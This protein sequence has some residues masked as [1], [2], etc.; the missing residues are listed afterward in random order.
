MRNFSIA[1]L[2]IGAALVLLA[3]LPAGTDS[4][5][6]G[7]VGI[8]PE[9]PQRIVSL[10]PG[11]TEIL[12]ALGAGDR[13]V[14]VTSY[15]DY[16][17]EAK[18]KPTVGGYHAP[19][20]EKVIALE[21]DMVFAMGE[22]QDKYVRMLR[23]AGIPVVAKEPKTM[24]E[25]LEAIDTISS[26]IGEEEAGQALRYDLERRLEGVRQRTGSAPPKQV[27][28]EVWSAPFLTVGSQSFINDLI[29][30]AGG[31][32]VVAHRKV[33]YTTC[34]IEALYSY[35][36]DVYVVIRHSTSDMVPMITRADLAD[37]GAVKNNQVFSV[38]DD[39]LVRPGPR[40]FIGLVKMAEIL[41]PEAMKQ[42][43]DK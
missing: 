11:N 19:D 22:I 42:A 6:G 30:Q 18:T 7:Q 21:P 39:L 13:V 24:G 5:S 43:G 1:L 35:N 29:T 38:D 41:H 25:I 34:D 31:T 16:P 10:S 12:F 2:I 27:F 36:P 23:K 4:E 9:K 26:A 40:S 33:D 20:L 32:N 8:S 3:A 14:G 28:L 17:P 37:L 15:S